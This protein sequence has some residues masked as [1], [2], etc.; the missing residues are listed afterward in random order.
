MS[1][2]CGSVFCPII[3]HLTSSYKNVEA[4][5]HEYIEYEWKGKSKKWNKVFV[6][7]FV[8]S[9]KLFLCFNIHHLH[10]TID[11]VSFCVFQDFALK[12]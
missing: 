1:Y 10:K 4:N 9:L 7:E 8:Q 6:L 12:L 5:V 2:N 11:I 3:L